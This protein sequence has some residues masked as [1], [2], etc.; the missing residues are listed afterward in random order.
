M[1]ATVG[2]ESGRSHRRARA[3]EHPQAESTNRSLV[4]PRAHP[5]RG[6]GQY[7]EPQPHDPVIV[8][9]AGRL[10]TASLEQLRDVLDDSDILDG[11]NMHHQGQDRGWRGPFRWS[12]PPPVAMF[13]PMDGLGPKVCNLSQVWPIAGC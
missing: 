13:C 11:A 12:M 1:A 3:D 10:K 4:W 5:V 9:E 2:A 6:S 7:P 8:D